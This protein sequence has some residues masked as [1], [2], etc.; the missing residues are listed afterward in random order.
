MS[1]DNVPHQNVSDATRA[2]RARLAGTPPPA[3]E[4]VNTQGDT[5][6]IPDPPVDTT[7]Q[8]TI[9]GTPPGNTT[10]AN[11]NLVS[12]T[13]GPSDSGL[14]ASPP[15][16]TTA[17]PGNVVPATPNQTSTFDAVE[18]MKQ[19]ESLVSNAFI[20]LT[21]IGGPALTS[22]LTMLQLCERRHAFTDA[23][24]FLSATEKYKAYVT[25]A[26]SIV[27]DAIAASTVHMPA[28]PPVPTPSA[29]P[30]VIAGDGQTY[31]VY[32]PPQPVKTVIDHVPLSAGLGERSIVEFVSNFTSLIKVP[33]ELTTL[34]CE[35]IKSIH[36]G[37][38][39]DQAILLDQ[40]LSMSKDIKPGTS[41]PNF[42]FTRLF[43][44]SKGKTGTVAFLSPT[45]TKTQVPNASVRLQLTKLPQGDFPSV[46]SSTQL[47]LTNLLNQCSNLSDNNMPSYCYQRLDPST[48]ENIVYQKITLAKDREILLANKQ[49][50]A[51]RLAVAI[52][53]GLALF[54]EG[55]DNTEKNKL[56]ALLSPIINYLATNNIDETLA[57]EQ[58]LFAPGQSQSM[59]SLV[60][61]LLYPHIQSAD[62]LTQWIRMLLRTSVNPGYGAKVAELHTACLPLQGESL[63]A[64]LQRV[65]DVLNLFNMQPSP[66]GVPTAHLGSRGRYP[67]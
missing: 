47:E 35:F 56:Q 39:A 8:G 46:N 57:R 30:T 17:L 26:T 23:S 21:K 27:T 36:S 20:N 40:L 66:M 5:L 37:S 62:Y 53:A 43:E 42:Q 3:S 15:A 14:S 2:S 19:Y 48:G 24:D 22:A 13:A 7:L 34:A 38:P 58:S 33:P 31:E 41:L 63:T 55:H 18:A 64:Q 4:E 44:D 51:K 67:T 50:V 59:S 9:N 45:D 54:L 60:E 12:Q 49:Q 29:K 25:A 28:I 6:H 11:T 61:S 1:N 32:T 16:G 52:V 65:Q 10:L